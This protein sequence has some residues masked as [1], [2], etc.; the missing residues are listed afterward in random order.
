MDNIQGIY[1]TRQSVRIQR[2]TH[3]GMKAVRCG[4]CWGCWRQRLGRETKNVKL[5]G[6]RIGWGPLPSYMRNYIIDLSLFLLL[7]FLFLSAVLPLSSIVMILLRVCVDV[8]P[9][10]CPCY[11]IDINTKWWS[12][13]KIF[14]SQKKKKKIIQIIFP[15]PSYCVLYSMAIGAADWTINYN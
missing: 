4:Y 13:P 1:A 3:A 9:P 10:V 7:L 11:F 12:H 8:F 15:W 2:H 5:S 6:I 14:T